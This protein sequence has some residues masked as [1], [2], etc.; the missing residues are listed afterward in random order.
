MDRHKEGGIMW[1]IKW[2][3][4]I[5]DATGSGLYICDQKTAQKLCDEANRRYADLEHWIEEGEPED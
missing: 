5:T 4:K 2:K 3:S 1:A